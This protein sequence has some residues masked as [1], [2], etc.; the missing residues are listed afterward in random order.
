MSVIHMYRRRYL[1]TSS[2]ITTLALAGCSSTTPATDT[3]TTEPDTP[4]A[5]DTTTAKDTETETAT[6]PSIELVEVS[7]PDGVSIWNHLHVEITL[8]NT[9]ESEGTWVDAIEWAYTRGPE[10]EEWRRTTVEVDVPG[11]STITEELEFEPFESPGV[12]YARFNDD[13]PETI[14]SPL[15]KAPIIEDANLVSEWTSYGDAVENKITSQSAGSL[16]TI[17]TRYWD[18]Q[19]N[20]THDTRYQ[21]K[22]DGADT[23][24]RVAI[25]SYEAEQLTD[26]SGWNR[27]ETV[28]RFDS[29]GWGTGEYIAQVLIRDEQNDEVSE[30]ATVTFELK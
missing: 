2:A 25:D 13:P 11:E 5:T 8:R 21:V 9:G 7:T 18:W 26:S 10:P 14:H 30:E 16:V 17:A 27:W 12:F 22:I 15:S 19:E 23:R 29:S 1:A 20:Q 4:T 3:A 24:E 6:P 28:L